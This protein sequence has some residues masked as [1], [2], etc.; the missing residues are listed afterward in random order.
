MLGRLSLKID[1]LVKEIIFKLYQQ[2]NE[3]IPKQD[4]S[5]SFV[6]GTSS[7]L[8]SSNLIYISKK[9]FGIKSLG[10]FENQFIKSFGISKFKVAYSYHKT[11]HKLN[12]TISQVSLMKKWAETYSKHRVQQEVNY[13]LRSDVG[14]Q[15][16]KIQDKIKQIS[17]KF[18]KM[19]REKDEIFNESMI[20]ADEQRKPEI[21]Q[22]QN[23]R[24]QERLERA[25]I[26]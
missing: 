3:K 21:E 11:D 13:M 26:P 20:D 2:I 15:Y 22:L 7:V 18:N 6:S 24:I 17:E 9:S 8:L 10:Y 4:E 16:I 1:R 12:F 19:L 5:D 14:E 25:S 23:E